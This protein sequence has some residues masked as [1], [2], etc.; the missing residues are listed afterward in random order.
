MKKVYRYENNADY[1]DRR[2]NEANNDADSFEN[3]DIYPIKY[4]EMI[5]NEGQKIC[6][7]GCGLGRVIKHYYKKGKD[8]SGMER[9]KV[10]V[11]KL[12]K[13]SPEILIKL[14]DV[15]DIPYE[16]ESFDTI[17]SFGVYHNLENGLEKA[18]MESRR[19]LKNDGKFCISMRPNNI[20]MNL[21]ELYWRWKNRKY[22]K[23]NKQFHKLLVKKNEFKELLENYHLRTDSVHYARNVS[24][25]YRVPFLR[26]RDNN[27][28]EN[29]L[30]SAGYN[31]N[32]VGMFI[33]YV[34]VKIFPFQTA[35]VIV[36][37]GKA[38]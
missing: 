5:V 7:I 2:W 22:R 25:L 35:N 16:D 30:R 28:S 19:I 9:S 20:E 34:L 6:E 17:L 23:K 27:L 13:E 29:V 14:G 8:V 36:F 31:L 24:I 1:W 26:K 21:N 33:N 38:V 11:D 4:A 10:A 37:I 32:V 18:L 3:L 12:N 15:L